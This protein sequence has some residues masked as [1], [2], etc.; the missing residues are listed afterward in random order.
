MARLTISIPET[1]AAGATELAAR[2]K[3]ST[4][5]YVALLIETDLRA[6]GLL[7]V[8]PLG[9]EAEIFSKL[10]AELAELTPGA[11]SAFIKQVDELIRT[12]RRAA[13]KAPAKNAA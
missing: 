4:S 7:P 11:R 8:D 9:S 2:N 13:R 5:A 6:A 3:R 10:Q 12:I 1:L